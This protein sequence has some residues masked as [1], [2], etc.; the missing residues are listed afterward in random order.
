MYVVF[1]FED[2]DHLFVVRLRRRWKRWFWNRFVGE[3]MR[4]Q[5]AFRSYI[6]RQKKSTGFVHKITLLVILAYAN[7]VMTVKFVRILIDQI[8]VIEQF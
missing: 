5:F 8:K 3:D 6:F 4:F 7:D 1:R 2:T